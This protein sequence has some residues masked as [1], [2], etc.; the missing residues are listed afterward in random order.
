MLFSLLSLSFHSLF[1]EIPHA[2]IHEISLPVSVAALVPIY[3]SGLGGPGCPAP[4]SATGGKGPAGTDDELASTVSRAIAQT[5]HLSGPGRPGSLAAFY[6][7]ITR[8]LQ[9]Q[10]E[11]KRER[12]RKGTHP[13]RRGERQRCGQPADRRKSNQTSDF[14]STPK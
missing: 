1:E 8:S 4:G 5:G 7:Q 12:R 14:C 9:Y 6:V 3:R 10:P 11:R 13:E 2:I